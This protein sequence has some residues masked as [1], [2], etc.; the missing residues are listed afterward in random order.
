MTDDC[1]QD[2][3]N[4]LVKEPPVL[5]PNYM[6]VCDHG[7]LWVKVTWPGSGK[8]EWA[9]KPL[10]LAE[11]AAMKERLLSFADRMALATDDELRRMGR[12]PGPRGQEFHG[13]NWLDAWT[14][15]PHD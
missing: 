8:A 2:C 15:A 7:A 9:R 4:A 11:R 3:H 6:A 10:T 14:E 12:N 5:F 13:R 1:L